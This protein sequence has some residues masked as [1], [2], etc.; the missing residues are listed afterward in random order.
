MW[1]DLHSPAGKRMHEMDLVD[2]LRALTS[3]N[4]RYLALHPDTPCLY[5]AGVRYEEEPLGQENWDDIHTVRAQKWGDC[6]D[7][8]CWR[9]AELIRSGVAARPV[10]MSRRLNEKTTLF[11]ILVRLPD[12]APFQGP[13]RKLPGQITIYPSGIRIEDPSKMLGMG[14]KPSQYRALVAA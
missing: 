8:A 1:V 4:L 13:P 9:A 11:H 2:Q 10:F 6:E 14:Q 5:H 12:V 3:H 7:L